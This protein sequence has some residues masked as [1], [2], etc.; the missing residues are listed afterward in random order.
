MISSGRALAV[1]A[2]N[3]GSARLEVEATCNYERR[4]TQPKV[5]GKPTWC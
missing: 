5:F 2:A 4:S 3:A 1:R